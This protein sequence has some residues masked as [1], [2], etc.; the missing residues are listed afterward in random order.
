MAGKISSPGSAFC[1]DS[2]FGIHSIPVI[3]PKMQM[4]GSSLHHMHHTCV[5]LDGCMV[6][7]QRAPRHQLFHEAAAM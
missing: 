7:T 5:A 3:L 1:A 4:A 2:Y 6:Y